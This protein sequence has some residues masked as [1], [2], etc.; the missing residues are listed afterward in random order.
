M[1]PLVLHVIL[2]MSGVNFIASSFDAV[3][4]A[5]VIPRYGNSVLGI[6][7]SCSGAAM[8]LGSLLVT[9]M[10]KPKNRVEVIYL[11]MLISLG[12]ENFIL[13]FSR[14][15]IF[16][17]MGQ[18]IGWILVPVMSANLNV[19]MRNSIPVDL[20][21]RV[22]A[23]RNTLQFF[24]IP[25]GLASGGFLVDRICEPFMAQQTGNSMPVLLF[26]RGKGSGAALMMFVLGLTGVLYCLVYGHILK[27]YKYEDA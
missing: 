20:Q 24:T 22:Y 7:T 5:L 6:V 12:T 8:V 3:L 27:R 18:V 16:W 19:I 4:P 17:C 21:G 25:I 9:V 14:N 10:K 11:S 13:A 2:F 23:C 1:N 26:G 15:P